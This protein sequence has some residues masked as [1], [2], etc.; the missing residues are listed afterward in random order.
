MERHNSSRLDSG[1]FPRKASKSHAV[2]VV[3]AKAHYGNSR[4]ENIPKFLRKPGG[5]SGW[6]ALLPPWPALCI[7]MDGMDAGTSIPARRRY[8]RWRI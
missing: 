6:S 8:A 4:H 2:L 3:C 7:D 5:V 1:F